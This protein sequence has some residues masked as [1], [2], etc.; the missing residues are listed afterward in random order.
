MNILLVKA[1]EVDFFM[2]DKPVQQ[3]SIATPVLPQGILHLGTWI[4][5]RLPGTRIRYVDLH[6]DAY[7]LY[8]AEQRFPD[9]DTWFHRRLWE[10]AAGE[11]FDIVGLS[12]NMNAFADNFHRT[13]RAAQETFPG[14]LVVAGGHYPSSYTARVADDPHLDHVV[15]GEGELPFTRL[16]ED[17]AQGRRGAERVLDTGDRINDF[18][19]FPELD[20][21]GVGTERYTK[22]GSFGVGE[23]A[24]RLTVLTSRGCPMHCTYCATH[25]VWDH[26]FRPQSPERM[27]ATLAFLKDRYGVTHFSFVDDNFLINKNRTKAFC[28]L[29][30]DRGLNIHWYP[31][32]AQVNSLDRESVALM[33]RSGCDGI[34][35]AIESGSKEVQKMIRKRVRLD[36]AREM[37]TAMREHGMNAQALFMFGFPGETLA[38]MEETIHYARSL[39]C[40]WY[41]GGI[42]TPLNGT[43][44]YRTCEENGFFTVDPGQTT[45]FMEGSIA[46]PDFTPDQVEE[47]LTRFNYQLNFL[48]N[49][50]FLSGDYQKILPN[51]ER[52]ARLYPDHFIVQYMLF[53]I[54]RSQGRRAEAQGM[55]QILMRLRR[56]DPERIEGLIRRFDL[57]LE[58]VVAFLE[59]KTGGA[60]EDS[61][62]DA[63]FS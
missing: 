16:A 17:W 48:E 25:S 53:R 24:R 26:G 20:W 18:N 36:H 63:D 28:R 6:L 23:E 33:A 47:M 34:A 2:L 42:A 44:M 3:R 37:M 13:A 59:K 39:E 21:D 35:V 40:D 32:T 1:P 27:V 49:R 31:S 10:A 38:Q 41:Y 56:D 30:L 60:E 5:D 43:E 50:A 12:A 45:T 51:Y 62:P 52:I 22:A 46:T 19:M 9:P 29:L 15:V 58:A 7:D 54:Y 4:K 14:A 55:A 11:K 61:R 57:D 8:Q